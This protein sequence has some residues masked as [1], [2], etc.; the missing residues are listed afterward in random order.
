MEEDYNMAY[1]GIIFDKKQAK[2]ITKLK[3][4]VGICDPMATNDGRFCLIM[5]VVDDNR[6]LFEKAGF[7]KNK[8]TIVS[9]LEPFMT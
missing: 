9:N 4:P 7:F 5:N 1:K 2:K 6:G 8:Q 3:L